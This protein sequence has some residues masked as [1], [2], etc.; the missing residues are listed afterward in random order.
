MW[1]LQTPETLMT[2]SKFFGIV[3][4]G[5]SYTIDLIK[6][7]KTEGESNAGDMR[8]KITRPSET[9]PHTQYP[10]TCV[11]E[12]IGGGLL[13]SGDDFMYQAP[14]TGYVSPYQLAFD[15]R[16]TNWTEEVKG[17]FYIKSR[18]G[19][20]YG[21]IELDIIAQ[22]NDKSVFSINYSLNA[23]GSRNLEPQ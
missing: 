14:E 6:G 11:V 22:Y 18:E 20:V 13:E 1:K 5:R 15:A 21:H 19:A 23:N 9:Q 12:T 8:V 7:T 17:N 3:P 2:G 10:W 16:Q 4:D